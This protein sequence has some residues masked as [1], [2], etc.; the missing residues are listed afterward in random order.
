MSFDVKN[1]NY[2]FSAGQ[3]GY[4]RQLNV[5]KQK[6]EKNWGSVSDCGNVIYSIIVTTDT[7]YLFITTHSGVIK[8][9]NLKQQKLIKQYKTNPS[10]A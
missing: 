1:T 3:K 6:L 7:K 5:K 4:L 9:W 2:I 10:K 8:Q